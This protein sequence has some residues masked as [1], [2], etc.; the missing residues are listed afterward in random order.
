VPPVGHNGDDVGSSRARRP[1]A[2]PRLT[3][4]RV[5]TVIDRNAARSDSPM[6]GLSHVQLPV[7]D[8]GASGEWYT[9][10]L[11]LEPHV[12][13]LD[14]GYVA[15]RHRGARLVIVLTAGAGSE[16][17]QHRGR[18]LQAGTET[19][20]SA[21]GSLDHLAF[22]VPDG[23]SLRTWADHL[24]EIGVDHVGVVLENGNP[25]LQLHDPDG[26]AIELVAPGFRS[27]LKPTDEAPTN[28]HQ[29]ET[30]VR[31]GVVISATE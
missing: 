29:K 22:A 18:D 23:D 5:R 28:G 15:L 24:T 16:A 13:D 3:F 14:I 4:A 1:T 21:C 19:S 30:M 8:V 31:N 20:D 7:S 2:L 26:I 17:E 27:D 12:E 6:T 10:A 9:A 11:G 25:S